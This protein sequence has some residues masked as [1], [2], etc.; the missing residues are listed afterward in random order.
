MGPVQDTYDGQA[1]N[2]ST[3]FL[4]INAIDCLLCHDG[5]GI[6]IT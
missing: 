4:G 3:M 6:W 5:A 1:V 2:L